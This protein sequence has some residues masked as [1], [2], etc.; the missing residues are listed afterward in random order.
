MSNYLFELLDR[1]IINWTQLAL[2]QTYNT[3]YIY[4][5]NLAL[6]TNKFFF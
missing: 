3:Q 1:Q 2:K 4:T 5:T 6:I